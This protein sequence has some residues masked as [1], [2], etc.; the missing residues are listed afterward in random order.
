M[1]WTAPRKCNCPH[2]I[3]HG[4]AVPPS[5]HRGRQRGAPHPKG[6]PLRGAVSR[7]LT[8]RSSRIC[9]NLSVSAFR[10]ATSPF[11]GGFFA[12]PINFFVKIPQ[13]S[14]P[15][16][17]TGGNMWYCYGATTKSGYPLFHL[18]KTADEESLGTAAAKY[19]CKGDGNNEKTA[20]G[21]C[22]GAGHDSWHIACYGNG[23][24]SCC[25]D[26]YVRIRFVGCSC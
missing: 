19:G 15:I 2:L 26:R 6:S 14:Y 18:Q 20:I 4:F 9:C 21:R 25:N 7:R 16:L 13:K 3:R 12:P 11:R 1:R 23:C 22:V 5:P 17:A 24:R 10:R 8:E